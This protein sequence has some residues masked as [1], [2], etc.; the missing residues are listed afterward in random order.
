MTFSGIHKE[1]AENMEGRLTRDVQKKRI[2]WEIDVKQMHKEFLKLY[3]ADKDWGSDDFLQDPFIKK[4]TGSTEVLNVE[5]M[6]SLYY[7]DEGTGRMI[8]RLRFDVKEYDKKSVTVIR[9]SDRMS[10][11][12]SIEDEDAPDGKE[13]FVRK[14]KMPHDV[15]IASIK[16][17]L[18]KDG[19]LTVEAPS[20]RKTKPCKPTPTP[21][22]SPYH[23]S[24]SMHM[25]TSMSAYSVG[26]EKGPPKLPKPNLPM[27]NKIQGVKHLLLVVQLGTEFDPRDVTVQA[28][29]TSSIKVKAKH[30]E[31][32]KERY[33]KHKFH[34]DYELPEKIEQT[35]LRAGL[36]T[37]GLL[38]IA[39]LAK[40]ESMMGNSISLKSLYLGN[41]EACNTESE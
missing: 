16:S 37:D 11:S 36:R 41:A 22:A 13:T 12:A 25:S 24:S 40:G 1:I 9:E 19:I 14:I 29:S 35:S 2:Q 4:R 28:N 6:R 7:E 31:V 27:F 39:A 17:Y 15:D 33:S 26:S 3:P 18:T 21:N 10:I 5:E 34:R 32:T 30:T 23:M 8:F 38:I 20:S